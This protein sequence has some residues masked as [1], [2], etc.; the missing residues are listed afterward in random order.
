MKTYRELVNFCV[1]TFE[2]IHSKFENN[3]IEDWEQVY[4]DT[5][6]QE[7]GNENE[8]VYVHLFYP[9]EDSI[10]DVADGVL[11]GVLGKKVLQA[12]VFEPYSDITVCVIITSKKEVYN[13]RNSRNAPR[14]NIVRKVRCVLRTTC[15]VS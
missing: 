1:K 10:T 12:V 3:E 2:D 11:N 5:L 7:L 9:G 8:I 6:E 14:R 13:G 15:R 4:F